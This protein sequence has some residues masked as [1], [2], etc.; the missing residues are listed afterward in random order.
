MKLFGVEM[1]GSD[2]G[3]EV[4]VNLEDLPCLYTRHGCGSMV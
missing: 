1:I 3:E 4:F 2:G